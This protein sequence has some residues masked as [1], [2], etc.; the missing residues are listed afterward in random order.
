MDKATREFRD[1]HRADKLNTPQETEH[2]HYP[3]A[4]F[5]FDNV[6]EMPL[7]AMEKSKDGFVKLVTELRKKAVGQ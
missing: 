7:P 6:I 1:D 5:A 4:S 3:E 2:A